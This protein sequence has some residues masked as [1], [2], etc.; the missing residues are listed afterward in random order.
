MSAP[1]IKSAKLFLSDMSPLPV[2]AINILWWH[3]QGQN[4]KWHDI[5][6]KIFAFDTISDPLKV[7]DIYLYIPVLFLCYFETW[8]FHLPDLPPKT[9]IRSVTIF[10]LTKE[11]YILLKTKIRSV[12]QQNLWNALFKVGSTVIGVKTRLIKK[13]R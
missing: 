9:K 12:G 8:L 2:W 10:L 1:N 13:N 7:W 3:C 4:M 11:C 5:F 6:F